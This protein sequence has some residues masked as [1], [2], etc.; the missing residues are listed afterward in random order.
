MTSVNILAN[1]VT[2]TFS[3]TLGTA[4]GD[5]LATTGGLDYIGTAGIFGL[6]LAGLLL[7]YVVPDID[8]VILF[9][10]A[11]ILTRPP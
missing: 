4:M 10:M 1:W 11:F 7:L 2:I 8:R 3:Q 5:R 9:W 6:G